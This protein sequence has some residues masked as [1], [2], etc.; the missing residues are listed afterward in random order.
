MEK[1]LAKIHDISLLLATVEWGNLIMV[2]KL[3]S[4]V[5]NAIA[6]YPEGA[7]KGL[8]LE[9]ARV[10]ETIEKFIMNEYKDRNKAIEKIEKMLESILDKADNAGE[11]SGNQQET[12][13]NNEMEDR[14]SLGRGQI[15]QEKEL[16]EYAQNALG[17]IEELENRM[18]DLEKS[19]S[20]HGLINEIFRIVHTLKG[21]T[22]FAGLKGLSDLLH[23]MEGVFS[24]LREKPVKIN[25][26]AED[27]LLNAVDLLKKTFELCQESPASAI[28]QTFG[29]QCDKFKALKQELK[30]IQDGA[31]F[32]ISDEVIG[33]TDR[34]IER[35]D[36]KEISDISI[37]TDF[38]HEA[39][40]HLEHIEVKILELETNPTDS[41]VLN[42][43]FRPLHTIKG[44]SGFLALKHINQISHDSESFLDKA[45]SGKI[46][47]DRECIDL[48]FEVV[49]VLRRLIHLVDMQSK[50][51]T[52]VDEDYPFV[53]ALIRKILATLEEKQVVPSVETTAFTVK[54]EGKLG[55]ILIEQNL[56]SAEDIED[57]LKAQTVETSPRKLGEILIDQDKVTPREISDALRKQMDAAGRQDAG[58]VKVA[59]EKLDHLIEIVGELVISQTLI[60]QNETVLSGRDQILSKNVSHL[61][62]IAR[63]IQ[64]VSMALRMVPVKATFQ[65]MA[66]LV[67]DLS[68]KA[69]KKVELVIEGAETELDKNVVEQINDP[70]IHMI[71]NSCDHGIESPEDRIR[72]GKNPTGK[73]ILNAYHQGGNIVIE[74]RD[75]GKGLNSE[76][77]RSKGIEKGMIAPDAKL[78]EAELFNLIFAPGFSTAKVI[79]DVSGRGVGMDVVKKNIEK[80]GGS[81]TISSEQGKGSL[82]TIRLPLTMA[83]LDGMVIR[84]GDEKFLL[85]VLSI[86]ESLRPVQK[87][88]TT[89]QNKGEVINVR[90]GLIQ[91]IRLHKIF[92]ITPRH[93]DPWNALVIIIDLMGKQFGFMVD[94]LVG[95]QQV[96][97]KSLKGE[98]KKMKGISGAAILGDGRVGLILDPKGLVE[99]AIN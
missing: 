83:I 67:R 32:S 61:S 66:R 13:Q 14:K 70:L 34:E 56:V 93:T 99:M 33:L 9:L 20:D 29:P 23:H 74:V 89:I 97:I 42:E 26:V 35:M 94:E 92:G 80:L 44:V 11:I 28:T 51:K 91:M 27:L 8:G 55:E 75:D 31:A 72:A 84:V 82:F 63:D 49:D 90:G 10:Q 22:G 40:E 95:Q 39:L 73:V 7:K 96:V 18:L 37:Y 41:A 36:L 62:K 46:I 30:D 38:I 16:C 60:A 21:E 79:T 88:A 15:L 5:E 59:T 68:L 57:A 47:M 98:F 87:D 69:N 76:A 71:R 64:Y 45:R 65:K 2:G 1:F 78:E 52:F 12:A 19:S 24:I 86:K 85:P 25:S 54:K 81:V 6:S 53:E 4:A 48:V 50:G 43:I 77:I 17:T 58:S 3:L